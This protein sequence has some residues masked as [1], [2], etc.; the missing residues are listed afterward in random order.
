MISPEWWIATTV[1]AALTQTFRSAIQRQMKPLLGDDGA[2]YIR[3]LYALPFAWLMVYSYHFFADVGFPLTNLRFWIWVNLA[4]ITQILFTV[5][6]IRIFSRR[7][8]AAG[9]AFSKTEVLQAAILEAIILG[10]MVSLL[11]GLAIILGVIAVVMLS[12]A[13]SALTKHDIFQSLF[14]RTS[15]IGLASGTFLGLATVCYK[16]AAISLEGGDLIM[17]AVYTGGIA[18]LIQVVMMGGWMLIF[19]RPQ[20]VASFVHWRGSIWAGFFGALAT[21]GWF[22]AFTLHSVAAVRAVGQIELLISLGVSLLWFREKTNWTEA[23]AIIMLTI[24]IIMVLM[25]S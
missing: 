23:L 8:F 25:G 14:S 7:S 1:F 21:V 15:A 11:T 2:S 16:A 5:L 19:T 17:R 22:T 12:F 3:F 10:V 13:K 6:L 18:T 4:S 20:L 9:T 24:S